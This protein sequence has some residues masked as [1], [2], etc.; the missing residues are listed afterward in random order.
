MKHLFALVTLASMFVLS[1]LADDLVQLEGKWSVKKTQE[2]Q[3]FTQTL[4]IK[5]D[6]FKFK[7]LRGN[8]EVALCAEGKL[9]LEKCGSF[10]VARFVEIKAGVS[11]SDLSA[12]D[13][14]YVS[15]YVLGDNLWTLATNFDKARDN[16]KPVLDAYVKVAK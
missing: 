12:I 15:I 14:S 6:T 11:E 9:K 2:G 1:A 10:N 7:V 13:D 4:E 16:Q 8:D 5:K 3:S